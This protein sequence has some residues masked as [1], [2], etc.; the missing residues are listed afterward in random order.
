MDITIRNITDDDREET[1]R[2]RRYAFGNSSSAPATPEEAA[3]VTAEDTVAAFDGG[4]MA[5]TL[6]CFTAPQVIRG[7]PKP[8]AGV[9]AVATDPDYRNRG[10]AREMMKA[11]FAMAHERGDAVSMLL[12]FKESFYARFGYVSGNSHLVVKFPLEAIRHVAPPPGYEY[13]TVP[14][15]EGWT[16]YSE[17]EAALTPRDGR[18]HGQAQPRFSAGQVAA[19]FK[20][21]LV[22]T[23]SKDGRTVAA[24]LYKKTGYMETGE[25]VA[26]DAVWEDEGA[27]AALF[28]FFL[29]HRDQI[30]FVKLPF[31]PAE[32][33]QRYL[34]DVPAPLTVTV[35]QLPWMV[36]VLDVVPAT[37]ALPAGPA[38]ELAFAVVDEWCPWNNGAFAVTSDG[39][40]LAARLYEGRP[41][42]TFDVRG[43]TALVYGTHPPERVAA[44]GWL[45]GAAPE[46]L[47]L[48]S[49]WFPP[50]PLFN[51][52]H[53]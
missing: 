33:F 18:H 49:A 47:G 51:T 7:V 1:V 39:A 41:E 23:V 19:W 27:R 8:M 20:E 30:G 42:L 2:V 48:L 29:R 46:V 50:L 11:A 3:A 34:R 12:P 9:S 37:T 53:F 4:R 17:A 28:A 52:F 6:T 40:R 24:A 16:L 25:L 35:R 22:V 36:R 10:V 13:R 21:A 45:R 26:H 14:A 15:T 32:N 38:G 5:G 31:S 43:L 44:E